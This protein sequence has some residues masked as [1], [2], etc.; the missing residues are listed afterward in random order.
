[1]KFNIYILFLIFV[2][3]VEYTLA[4]SITVS[5]ATRYVLPLNK[6][7][8]NKMT[9]ISIGG[10]KKMNAFE[11]PRIYYYHDGKSVY[12]WLDIENPSLEVDGEKFNATQNILPV[13]FK[14]F[15]QNKM[16]IVDMKNDSMTAAK[17]NMDEFLSWEILEDTK[18]I[19][20]HLCRKAISHKDGTMVEAW[21]AK[22]IGIMDGPE[23][24]FGLPGL[25]LE[26]KT[27]VIVTRAVKITLNEISDDQV[28]LPIFANYITYEQYLKERKVYG[29]V[30]RK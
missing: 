23:I 17:V 11:R 16:H 2:L 21:F 27:G 12:R 19:L 28:K 5:Y 9:G 20:G 18:V 15:A 29:G 13:F 14:D 30:G 3:R 10:L 4:Q 22:D 26:V 8:S 25:I 24:Y 1:M 7:L 6:M